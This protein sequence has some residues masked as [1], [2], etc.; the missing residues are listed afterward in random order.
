MNRR[1]SNIIVN[2]VAAIMILIVFY[3]LGTLLFYANPRRNRENY[4]ES[5]NL[6]LD[7]TSNYFSSI[8]IKKID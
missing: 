4:R 6:Y 1:P 2:V 3:V 5:K 8:C 7:C